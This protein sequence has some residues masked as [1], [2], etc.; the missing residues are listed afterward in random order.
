MPFPLQDFERR[1]IEEHF[2]KKGHFAWT[3]DFFLGV[4]R[5]SGS[6]YDLQKAAIGLRQVGTQKALQPLIVLLAYPD[7]DVQ[8][9]AILT[10]SH[11]AGAR[12]TPIFMEALAST[13]YR[14][15]G[16]ALWAIADSADKRAIPAV[17]RYLK[18]N[19]S[20]FKCGSV[21]HTPIRY[22]VDYLVRLT[23]CDD[24]AKPLLHEIADFWPGLPERER[25][26]ILAK[27]PELVTQLDKDARPL[28]PKA[29]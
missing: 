11:I 29:K 4:V 6:K 17:Q 7:F 9:T 25:K 22:V 28:I 16:Y 20:R 2:L 10:I 18:K 1:F 27:H 15:K 12:A 21:K 13:A 8:A 19:K 5:T 14:Q 23:D 3:E 24:L 26:E